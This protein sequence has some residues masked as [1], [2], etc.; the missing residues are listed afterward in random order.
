MLEVTKCPLTQDLVHVNSNVFI[1]HT[2]PYTVH[3]GWQFFF[4]GGDI[5]RQLV[6]QKRP[7]VQ[8]TKCP[9]NATSFNA[10][11]FFQIASVQE[12]TRMA[13]ATYKNIGRARAANVLGMDLAH[14]CS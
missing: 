5:G 9:L 7:V 3:D 12:L 4:C 6:K 11:W 14:F 10:P 13:I 8:T 1:Y 2:Y